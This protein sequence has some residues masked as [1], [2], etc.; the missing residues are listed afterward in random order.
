MSTKIYQA[1]RVKRSRLNEFLDIAHSRMFAAARAQVVLLMRQFDPADM[2][3]L[4]DWVET[5]KNKARAARNIERRRRYDKAIKLCKSA[6]ESHLR[7]PTCD[8]ECGLNIWLD[9]RYAYAIPYGEG[10][11]ANVLRKNLPPW[12][13]D[14]AY[15]NNTDEPKDVSWRA[16]RA[17]GRKWNKLCLGEGKQSWNARRLLHVVVDLSPLTGDWDLRWSIVEQYQYPKPKAKKTK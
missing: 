15:W 13:E 5:S 7:N 1:Y 8:I 6:A 11:S 17:R 10:K 3:P 16:W 14:Y 12:I 2:P 4:P 9:A